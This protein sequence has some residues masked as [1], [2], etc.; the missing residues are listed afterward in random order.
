ME[1]ED[2][3]FNGSNEIGVNGSHL[4]H[5]G[6][7]E[8]PQF[9]MWFTDLKNKNP[10]YERFTPEW[11]QAT[12]KIT[13]SQCRCSECK[14]LVPCRKRGGKTTYINDLLD[15]HLKKCAG[16]AEPMLTE[17]TTTIEEDNIPGVSPEHLLLSRWQKWVTK[18]E[19][20]N[21]VDVL[22]QENKIFFKC[23]S[24]E[25]ACMK[26]ELWEVTF[27]EKNSYFYIYN[28]RKHLQLTEPSI[29]DRS[30]GSGTVQDIVKFFE[31][32]G[33]RY[34]VKPRSPPFIDCKH[35]HHEDFKCFFNTSTGD[36]ESNLR[37]HVEGS[38]HKASI[39]RKKTHS[40]GLLRF[41]FTLIAG[42]QND[43]KLS[44]FAPEDQL[45]ASQCHG[46]N[47]DCIPENIRQV[48]LEVWENSHSFGNNFH[49]I[50]GE[51]KFKKKRR[52]EEGTYD[53]IEVSSLFR[54]E[55][56]ELTATGDKPFSSFCCSQCRRVRNDD[57]GGDQAIQRLIS[58]RLE[59]INESVAFGHEFRDW[60]LI[61]THR[62]AKERKLLMMKEAKFDKHNLKTARWQK[63]NIEHPNT[64][65]L[66][67]QVCN[68]ERLGCE[69]KEHGALF[70]LVLEQL[71]NEF[72]LF[73]TGKKNGYRQSATKDLATAINFTSGGLAASGVAI[74]KLGLEISKSTVQRANAEAISSIPFE[75]GINFTNIEFAMK[76]LHEA[77][78]AKGKGH[79]ITNLE[80]SMDESPIIEGYTAQ[81]GPDGNYIVIRGPCGKKGDNHECFTPSIS[82]HNRE[83]FMAMI[84]DYEVSNN[85]SVIM[86]NPVNYPD[87]VDPKDL[88]P[89]P[90]YVLG[91]CNTFKSK[92][93]LKLLRQ[94][95]LYFC[96]VLKEHPE[97]KFNL[98]GYA[99]DG[100]KRRVTLQDC[101]GKVP[102]SAEAREVSTMYFLDNSAIGYGGRFSPHPKL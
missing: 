93:I 21:D 67:E 66:L 99:S 70:R 1:E 65:Q 94:I 5:E 56:C 64:R 47:I 15:N 78:V 26:K 79:V 97:Y 51:T 33:L 95:T 10:C 43:L 55:N 88:K 57:N 14:I 22:M 75:D 24:T 29:D 73:R 38:T 8:K 83:E 32:N 19:L 102:Q 74:C 69:V 31:I 42:A 98:I 52:G 85:L 7:T 59:G 6:D 80:L 54:S 91:T 25:C 72:S 13:K 17:A 46:F 44:D 18:Q 16:A 101:I 34:R 77:K 58:R 4:L 84:N 63:H 61:R 50:R 87:G 36:L 23:I 9:E 35:C 20:T 41:G 27:Y 12:G 48:Y 3:K 100:D 11:S 39:E 92:D 81:P 68:M 71:K 2:P 49:A 62:I 96:K 45:S 86:L 40:G 53:E 28:W 76:L 82:I 60:L 90:I 89:L 30:A 37:S